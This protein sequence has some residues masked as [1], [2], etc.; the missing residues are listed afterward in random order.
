VKMMAIIGGFLGWPAAILVLI[1]GSVLG[2]IVGILQVIFGKSQKGMK[3]KLPFGVFLG[4]AAIIAL[5][6]GP[7]IVQ[8]YTA[9]LRP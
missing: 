9:M 5:F 8:W 1:L 2:S 7:M 3:T 6:F 4:I